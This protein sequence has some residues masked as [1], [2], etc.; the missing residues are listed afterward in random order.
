MPS[1]L[2]SVL[3]VIHLTFPFIG[4]GVKRWPLKSAF[5]AKR[6][7]GQEALLYAL[8]LQLRPRECRVVTVGGNFFREAQEKER[9]GKK[10]NKKERKSQE[11]TPREQKTQKRTEKDRKGQKRT[12]SPVTVGEFRDNE[13]REWEHKGMESGA[14]QFRRYGLYFH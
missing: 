9:K 7:D 5:L 12:K 14:L 1:V 10:V 6:A 4:A 11:M 2:L 13:G 8:P 3:Q